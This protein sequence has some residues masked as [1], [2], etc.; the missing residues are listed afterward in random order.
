MRDDAVLEIVEAALVGVAQ[1]TIGERELLHAGEGAL[2]SHVRVVAARKTAEGE[3]DG[4][5][6]GIGRHTQQCVI[7]QVFA[8]LAPC[9]SLASRAWRA[10]RQYATPNEGVPAE[11]RQISSIC[12]RAVAG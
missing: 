7:V 8:H 4:F 2:T 6:V 3:A 9:R 11:G 10:R 12:K 5:G 1:D